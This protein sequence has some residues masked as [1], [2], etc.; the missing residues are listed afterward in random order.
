[1]GI[2]AGSVQYCENDG[3]WR[4]TGTAGTG[5]VSEMPTRGIPVRNP[6][7]IHPLS[8]AETFRQFEQSDF[9]YSIPY[10]LNLQTHSLSIH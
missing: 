6:T 2:T 7:Y 4:V 9:Q 8:I 10:Q 5:T 3:S 1:M